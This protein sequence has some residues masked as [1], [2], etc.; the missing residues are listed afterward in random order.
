[1]WI[2][3]TIGNDSNNSSEKES[4]MKATFL[5]KLLFL[6]LVPSPSCFDLYRVSP[7]RS[8]ENVTLF[9]FVII[10]FEMTKRSMFSAQSGNFVIKGSCNVCHVIM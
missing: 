7:S 8:W 3:L 1:M 9:S 4:I 10:T 5:I 2:E 6:N